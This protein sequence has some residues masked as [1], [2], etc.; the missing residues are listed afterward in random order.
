M[1]LYECKSVSVYMNLNVRMCCVSVYLRIKYY[2]SIYFYTQLL[3]SAVKH[4]IIDMNLN[5][6]ICSLVYVCVR[7][8]V[9]I[10]VYLEYVRICVC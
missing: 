5:V 1:Q 8:F 10:Y 3:T 6:C 7:V 4:G 9:Y 2:T